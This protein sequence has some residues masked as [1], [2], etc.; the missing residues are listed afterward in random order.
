MKTNILNA[1]KVSAL[2]VVLSFGLSYVYAWTAP[3][4]TPPTGNVSAPLNTGGDL[5]TKSGNLTVANLGANAIVF[6]DATTLSTAPAG[7][8]IAFT[9]ITLSNPSWT[10]NPKTKKM[11]VMAVGG[12]GGGGG[13]GGSGALGCGYGGR[14]GSSAPVPMR[15]GYVSSVSGTYNVTI[16]N[17]GTSGSAGT[18]ANGAGGP[19]GTGGTTTFGTAINATGGVGGV[20]G[21]GNTSCL[22]GIVAGAGAGTAHAV[23]GTAGATNTAGGVA[24]VNSSA[25]GGGGGASTFPN[26][27]KTGGAGGSGIVYVWEYN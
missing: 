27:G 12:G 17:G 23:G 22:P 2:A 26:G 25:G 19:G 11:I 13:S 18:Y 5:Q 4:A 14:G 20:G 15:L 21:G 8:L 1:L 10:P 6:P 24:Q 3:S 9:T 7:N 16:G